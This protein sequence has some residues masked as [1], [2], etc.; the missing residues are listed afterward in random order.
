MIHPCPG[1]YR[2]PSRNFSARPPQHFHTTTLP[3]QKNSGFPDR[4]VFGVFGGSVS[5]NPCAAPFWGK[6][7]V[8][9]EKNRPVENLF[10]LK[11]GSCHDVLVAGG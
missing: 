4:P 1:R 9:A 3:R 2:V 5:E 11:K 7:Q 6:F 8:S 10:P